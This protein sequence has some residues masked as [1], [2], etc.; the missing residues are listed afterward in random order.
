MASKGWSPRHCPSA[1]EQQID[2]RTKLGFANPNVRPLVFPNPIGLAAGFD[3][4]GNIIAPMFALGF[5][6]VEIGTVTLRPQSGNPKPRLFRLPK[7]EGLINRY[8]FNSAGAAVVEQNLQ[9]YYH[10][11][12]QQQQQVQEQEK[13]KS[14]P[15]WKSSL[16]W[17]IPSAT[18]N[19]D[20]VLGINIGKNK[21]TDPEDIS[22]VV[23]DYVEL[24]ARLGIYAD[25]LVINISSPNTPNLRNYQ[26]PRNLS[27]L[28]SACIRARNE[29][30]TPDGFVPA[31]FVKLAPDLEDDELEGIAKCCMSLG[32]NGND[33][34]GDSCGVDGIV[35]ANT[36]SQ[37]PHELLSEHTLKEQAGGL[38][39][40]P[41][42]DSSTRIIRKLYEI[43]QGKL[44]IIGVGGIGNGHDA[45]EKLKAGASL[46]QIY[47]MM[48][49]HGPGLVSTIR[50]ELAQLMVTNGERTLNDVVGSDHEEIFLKRR[51][52][53]DNMVVVETEDPD[54]DQQQQH[55][56][57][58]NANVP[59]ADDE[60]ARGLAV[61]HE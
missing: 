12:Q 15:W 16:L 3:K 53:Q 50:H 37:R 47:S 4:N 56:Q 6:A 46:V 61:T 38:S 26:N 10:H 49:Y 27:L 18:P 39:G 28:L 25:Y 44:I 29:V 13:E 31:L 8:G 52:M 48:V 17:W 55:Q 5:G 40:K 36:T 1:V 20:G 7:D 21:D 24:I 57:Q 30:V 35:I 14:Y 43:T 34:D 58:N 60:K 11:K 45:Y 51:L 59:N 23:A 22:A 2:V 9:N 54:R 41:I 42:R 32:K 33:D 19:L